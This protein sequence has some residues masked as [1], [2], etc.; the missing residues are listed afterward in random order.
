MTGLGIAIWA[1]AFVPY[2]AIFGVPTSRSLVIVWALAAVLLTRLGDLRAGLRSL[3]LDFL[4]LF[5]GL[6]IYDALR[7]R[8]DDLTPVAHVDPQMAFDK[9]IG[10]G[11]T[12]TERL[13]GWLYHPGHPHWYDFVAWSMH[14]SHFFLSTALLVVLWRIGSERFRPLLIGVITLSYAALATYWLYPA[15]PPWM[16]S[17]QG[18]LHPVKRVIEAVWKDEGFH[19]APKLL[20]H[21]GVE[22]ANIGAHKVPAAMQA[23]HQKKSAFSDPVAAL[24]SLHAAIP[25]LLF[26]ALRGIRG[27][28]T[29]LLAFYVVLMGVSLVYGG[30]HYTFDV[31]MGWGYAAGAWAVAM[32]RVPARI[33]SRAGRG[34]RRV[35]RAAALA[36]GVGR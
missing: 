30:E 31:F 24:P 19:R 17:D 3:V 32:H 12:P 18:H 29:V 21:H 15:V 27:W 36:T 11:Q 25:M 16:A 10:F 20:I 7:G 13:Q 2:V 1:G 23:A 34:V 26:L 6:A 22:P 33:G 35:G 4:P 28:I 9:A 5:A 8:A 14:L